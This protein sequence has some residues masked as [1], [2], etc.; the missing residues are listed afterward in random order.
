VIFKSTLPEV[1]EGEDWRSEGFALKGSKFVWKKEHKQQV[2]EVVKEISN[3]KYIVHT[4][5]TNPSSW[6]RQHRL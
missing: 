2:E 4:D 6:I 3:A 5:P 1:L